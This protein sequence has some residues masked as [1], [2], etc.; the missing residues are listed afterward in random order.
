M[1]DQVPPPLRKI[2]QCA[3]RFWVVQCFA[4]TVQVPGSVTGI[5][6]FHIN[7]F[8]FTEK[9]HEQGKIPVFHHGLVGPAKFE[10]YKSGE[11]GRPRPG[12]AS[13]RDPAFMNAEEKFPQKNERRRQNKQYYYW[14]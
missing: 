3:A 12:Y 6:E 13:L 7:Q 10:A 1:Q 11:S 5:H 14:I 4:C 8:I 9:T 2:D